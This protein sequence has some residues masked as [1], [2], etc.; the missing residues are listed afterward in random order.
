MSQLFHKIGALG[1]A[2]MVLLST[3][4][5]TIDRHYCGKI[6]V[7]V[8]INKTAKK[9]AMERYLENSKSTI[10]KPSCCKD[11]HQLVLGQDELNKNVDTALELP[12]FEAISTPHHLPCHEVPDTILHI[13]MGNHDPPDM[14]SNFQQ[15]YQT[16]LI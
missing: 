11:E 15:L 6:L 9:C 16:Y 14:V 12:V 13:T 10:T 3:T 5:F 7:D 8:A 4:S 1:L 2:M